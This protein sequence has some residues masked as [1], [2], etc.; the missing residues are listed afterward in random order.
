MKLTDLQEGL[1]KPNVRKQTHGWV[2]YDHVNE[3]YASGPRNSQSDD[4]RD[5]HIFALV[6]DANT[7]QELFGRGHERDIVGHEDDTA[8]ARQILAN[9]ERDWS[10]HG[11]ESEEAA[12]KW[13]NT[14]LRSFPPDT[15]RWQVRKVR[16]TYEF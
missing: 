1:R 7:A 4:I 6:E 11:H 10:W 13:A 9:P 5:I 2:V 16:V 14:Q 15:D 8:M 12:V 3:Q